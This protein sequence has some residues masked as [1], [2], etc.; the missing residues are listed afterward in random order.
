MAITSAATVCITAEVELSKNSKF[1]TVSL[2]LAVKSGVGDLN[3]V[4]L[5]HLHDLT[6]TVHSIDTQ[7]STTTTRPHRCKH[8]MLFKGTENFRLTLVVFLVRYV[9][10]KSLLRLRLHSSVFSF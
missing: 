7:K 9:A 10:V 2:E 8:C 3:A 4:D 5:S 1:S 6:H